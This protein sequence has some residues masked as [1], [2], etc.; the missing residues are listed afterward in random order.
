MALATIQANLQEHMREN[1]P[2]LKEYSI[3]PPLFFATLYDK[4]VF[5]AR[6]QKKIYFFCS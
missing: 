6:K 1:T 4:A 5:V 2:T 3:A